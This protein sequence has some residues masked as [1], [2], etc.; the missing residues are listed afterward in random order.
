MSTDS[1]VANRLALRDTNPELYAELES[2]MPLVSTHPN[3]EAQVQ[4][5]PNPDV[6]KSMAQSFEGAQVPAPT[7]PSV[8]QQ[9]QPPSQLGALVS[10]LL[11]DMNA[12]NAKKA[13]AIGPDLGGNGGLLGTGL[14]PM[15]ALMYALGA[16][17]TSRLPQA[18]AMQMTMQIGQLPQEYE[19]Q[20]HQIAQSQVQSILSGI[21]ATTSQENVQARQAELQKKVIENKRKE[22]FIAGVDLSKGSLTAAEK[23]RGVFAGVLPASILS[24][25][26][27]YVDSVDADGNP[28]KVVTNK[29]TGQPLQDEQGRPTLFPQA[30]KESK[31]LDINTRTVLAGAK[32]AGIPMTINEARKIAQ[33][34]AIEVSRQR[35]FLLPGAVEQRKEI[36]EAGVRTRERVQAEQKIGDLT[37]TQNQLDSIFRLAGEIITAETP[38]QATKQAII[39]NAAGLS[40][41]TKAGLYNSIKTGLADT[42]AR[43]LGGQRGVLTDADIARTTNLF[44]T[45]SDTKATAAYKQRYLQNALSLAFDA[46]NA[47][48]DGKPVNR[49][50]I[51][52][53][54]NDLLDVAE[55]KKKSGDY[56]GTQAE[57]IDR[58]QKEIIELRRGGKTDLLP[59]GAGKKVE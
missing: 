22:D 13:K 42:L 37:Q 10:K 15:T 49:E 6:V 52:K 36:Q 19:R 31:D 44:P 33:E 41:S 43:T 54:Y 23:L 7:V 1:L 57:R 18:Q 21:N 38:T 39:L 47:Q 30:S 32:E 50:E 46:T 16:A 56:I 26:V 40:S 45:F 3:T 28:I 14:S 29:M 11:E 59:P 55:G 9:S 48:I 35:T 51:R 5:M 58:L 17:A 25:D 34:Q 53:K 4:G 8:P 12:E 20:K 27:D 2:R 24:T